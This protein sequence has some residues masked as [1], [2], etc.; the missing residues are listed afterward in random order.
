MTYRFSFVS[1]HRDLIDAY[2]AERSARAGRHPRSRGLM[3]F[4]GVLWFGGFFFLGPGAFRD[5]PLISFAWL[6]LGVFVT[7]KMGLKPLIE[8]QRITKASKP[9]QQLDISFTDEGMAT[10]T[11]EGGSY[12]RAWAELEAVEAARL[13]VLLGFS[14]GVRNWVPNRAFAGDE[15]KQAFVAYLRGRMG[16]AKA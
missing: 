6:A 11:P 7:W 5:A 4:V 13:G 2:D 9:Q 15:E 1:T 12:A 14:D 3:W 8:R 10:V 16:A